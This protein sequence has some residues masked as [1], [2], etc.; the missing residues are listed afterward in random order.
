[1]DDLPGLRKQ[2]DKELKNAFLNILDSGAY[3]D[4]KIRLSDGTEIN[5]HRAILSERCDFFRNALRSGFK[6]SHTGVIEMFNDPPEAV[7]AMVTYLYTAEY[8][9]NG[10]DGLDL[11]FYHLDVY[12][13]AATYLVKGL[14]G[15][16]G[17]R[18][19]KRLDIT[20]PEEFLYV[21]NAL[22]AFDF[23]SGNC[24]GI[25]NVYWSLLGSAVYCFKNVDEDK[26]TILF[27]E[28]PA[29]KEDVRREAWDLWILHCDEYA[30]TWLER[31]I[32]PRA[33]GRTK[34]AITK[35]PLCGNINCNITLS[36]FGFPMALLEGLILALA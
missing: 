14:A 5:C 30:A 2:E 33:T 23:R 13:I 4:M 8:S 15:T 20:Q 16:A 6:E 21:A 12:I 29:F 34:C 22:K 31:F 17:Y 24:A 10:L 27:E 7:R 18:V 9:D 35:C 32:G 36:E 28:D 25:T 1:M 26:W 11:V 19:E 3:S